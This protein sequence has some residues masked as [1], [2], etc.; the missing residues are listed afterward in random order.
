MKNKID[1]QSKTLNG[2]ETNIKSLM[3]IIKSSVTNDFT[4][5][6]KSGSADDHTH[7]ID[8]RTRSHTKKEQR[9]ISAKK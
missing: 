5:V 8:D 1:D 4:M 3:T 7:T 6:G 2:L 9:H